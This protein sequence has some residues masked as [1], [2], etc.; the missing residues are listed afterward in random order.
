MTAR[1]TDRKRLPF[2]DG[3][4]A[5]CFLQQDAMPGKKQKKKR[6]REIVAMHN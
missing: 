4:L 3:N 2:R 6:K 1:S 5:D